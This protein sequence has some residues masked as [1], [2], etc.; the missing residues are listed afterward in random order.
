MSSFDPAVEGFIKEVSKIE[1]KYLF[2][3]LEEK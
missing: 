2:Y 1:F 3:I